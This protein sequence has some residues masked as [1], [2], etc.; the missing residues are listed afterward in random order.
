MTW[1]CGHL[2]RR[3]ILPP[4]CNPRSLGAWIAAVEGLPMAFPRWLSGEGWR[5]W[6][7]A[8]NYD[9][10]NEKLVGGQFGRPGVLYM[11]KVYFFFF[12]WLLLLFFFFLFFREVL[13]ISFYDDC[14][15]FKKM[16]NMEVTF[17]FSF[18]LV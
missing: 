12:F 9:E 5:S 4:A 16:K 13:W 17:S 2:G 15:N 7:S 1:C 18:S 8:L 3:S 14:S 6:G 10:F 11:Q